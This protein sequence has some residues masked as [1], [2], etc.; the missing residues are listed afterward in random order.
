MWQCPCAF[1]DIGKFWSDKS[2]LEL[3]WNQCPCAFKDIGKFWWDI[4]ELE[5]L[6]STILNSPTLCNTYMLYGGGAYYTTHI[7]FKWM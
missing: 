4:S 7:I 1:I 3:K 6:V 5:L 2:E